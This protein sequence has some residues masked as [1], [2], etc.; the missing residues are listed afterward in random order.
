MAIKQNF[1]QDFTTVMFQPFLKRYCKPLL[2]FWSGSA[3]GNDFRKP[4]SGYTLSLF[5]YSLKREPYSAPAVCLRLLQDL[6]PEKVRGSQG[7]GPC[8]YDLLLSL[9]HQEHRTS[10]LQIGIYL[11]R[12]RLQPL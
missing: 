1:L 6:Y 11:R 8:T 10:C 12:P 2:F 3:S 5:R 7:H 9:S 4:F